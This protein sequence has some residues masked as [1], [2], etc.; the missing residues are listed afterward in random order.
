M[1]FDISSSNQAM[2]FCDNTGQLSLISTITTPE[3]QFNNF[4]RETEFPDTPEQLPFVSIND[5]S[6]PLSSILLPHTQTGTWLSDLPKDMYEYRYRR[7][8]HID[9]I[10]LNT[11]KTQGTISYA[12]N[13]R[14]TRRNQIPYIMETDPSSTDE[15]EVSSSTIS[16]K[17]SSSSIPKHYQKLEIQYKGLIEFDFSE[18]NQ[19]AFSGLEAIL[20]NAYCNAM[21][22][23]LFFVYPLRKVL[24]SH[25]CSK[26]FCLSCELGFL[27]HMLTNN[28]GK[29]PCQ[30][31]NFLR[32][33]RTVP[34]VS[35]LGLVI[36]DR[37]A[38]RSINLIQLIQNWNRFMLHQ[39]HTELQESRKRDSKTDADIS[40]LITSVSKR[41]ECTTLED[42][43][44]KKK[45]SEQEEKEV[46]ERSE[47]FQK[48]KE[49]IFKDEKSSPSENSITNE[50]TD[51]SSL[52]GIKQ[53]V[54]HR[55]LKCNEKKLKDN[56]VMVCNLLYPL[57]SQETGG[58]FN[59]LLKASMNVEKTLSAWCDPCNRFS[60]HNHCTRVTNLP[61]IL[62]VN[63][64]LDNDKELDY[65]KKYLNQLN[66]DFNHSPVNEP[67]MTKACR[68][69]I[70]CSRPDCHFTHP[71][72]KQSPSESSNGTAGKPC[73][74]WFPINF[75][76][77]ITDAETISIEEDD[78]TE[79]ESTQNYS[80]QAAV[81]CIDDGQQRNLI[82]FILRHGQWFIFNDFCI[83]KVNEDEVLTVILEWKIPTVLFYK[84]KGFEW[85]ENEIIA[86]ESPFTSNLLL[87]EKFFSKYEFDASS[88][89]PL[90]KDE[91]PQR[92]KMAKG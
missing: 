82:A 78:E 90:T 50:E 44:A 1:S 64:G 31:S 76:A 6:F 49:E 54:V 87:E 48:E 46:T 2:G 30:A 33:F 32:S 5:T 34:E 71:Q 86:F 92:G 40:K 9:P 73:D 72:R 81:Y 27:F 42:E 52:F 67:L 13:P 89:L 16:M 19:T 22:Q 58:D 25:T 47:K 53:A 38:G 80:L 60:P 3:P 70:K 7:S 88:F 41:L 83:K 62:A 23:I 45:E 20:P 51:V 68:Y 11:M 56:V 69:G 61:K 29:H 26:E 75:K 39:M 43:E 35:A 24:L 17:P 65:L 28:N 84:M 85:N 12:P 14:T 4:S 8:K 36:S 91:I 59:K 15:T 37:N 63:C 18:Y 79:D 55:C 57:N 10:I 66:Q 77:L 74:R 21:L